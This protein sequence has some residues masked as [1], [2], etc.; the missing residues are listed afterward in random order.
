MEG[1]DLKEKNGNEGRK[2]KGTLAGKSI[3]ILIELKAK[4]K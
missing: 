1:R 4:F 3:T 2:R